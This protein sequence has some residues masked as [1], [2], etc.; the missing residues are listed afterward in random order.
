MR[1]LFRVAEGLL[2]EMLFA[3]GTVLIGLL[4]AILIWGA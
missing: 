1:R 2:S 4:A 3:V